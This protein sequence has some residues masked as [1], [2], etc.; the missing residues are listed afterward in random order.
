MQ[1]QDF[2]CHPHVSKSHSSVLKSKY[3]WFILGLKGTS[4]KRCR[5]NMQRLQATVSC[6]FPN[7]VETEFLSAQKRKK[8]SGLWFFLERINKNERCYFWY[9]VILCSKSINLSGLLVKT[10]VLIL[11]NAQKINSHQ[12]SKQNY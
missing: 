5:H 2:S 11:C 7:A 8:E 4:E 6:Y 12:V 1:R 9:I 10:P 3:F